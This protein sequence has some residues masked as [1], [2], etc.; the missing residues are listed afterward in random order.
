ML[1]FSIN[2]S[3]FDRIWDVFSVVWF[4]SI[5]ILIL[6]HMI[7]RLRSW[8]SMKCLYYYVTLFVNIIISISFYWYITIPVVLI[9]SIVGCWIVG[10]MDVKKCH[11]QA[12]KGGYAL[13]EKK[14]LE[15]IENFHYLSISEQKAYLANI[16]PI[17]KM[18]IRAVPF[19]LITGLIPVGISILLT[20]IYQY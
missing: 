13:S 12:I 1:L 5:I 9:I 14:R 18:K 19:I 2:A 8:T 10:R 15:Q 7:F 6:V 3:L 20:F 16:P 11:E 17:E 4:I